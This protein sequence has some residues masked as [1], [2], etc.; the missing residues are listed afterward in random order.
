M[1]STNDYG[2]GWALRHLR[3][4]EIDLREAE[5]SRLWGPLCVS[6]MRHAQLALYHALG[7]RELLER[8]VRGASEADVDG[9]DPLLR[10]LIRVERLIESC[11]S[12][13]GGDRGSRLREARLVV[14][15]ASRVVRLLSGGFD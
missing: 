1:F 6:A 13:G 10:Y 11:S 4:A 8:I 9:G 5:A 3:E 12:D 15:L 2:I 7:D 14:D